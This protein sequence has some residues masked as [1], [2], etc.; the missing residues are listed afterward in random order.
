MKCKN[1]HHQN[2]KETVDCSNGFALIEFCCYLVEYL[3]IK[4]QNPI[5]K[6]L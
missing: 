4:F 2:E 5:D 6:S 1:H 3:L